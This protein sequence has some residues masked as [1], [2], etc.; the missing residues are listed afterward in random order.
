M[1]RRCAIA[2]AAALWLLAG[3]AQASEIVG[4]YNTGASELEGGVSGTLDVRF[5]ACTDAPGL[6]CGTI[7]AAH[8][9]EDGSGETEMP[10]GQP[11][12]GFTMITG[13]EPRGEGR[14]RDGKINAVDESLDKGK[15]VWYGV[16]VD[17]LESGDLEL[18]GCLGFLCPRKLRWT[19]IGD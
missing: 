19:R 17:R 10:D 3:G 5:H 7:E 9:G 6:T 2:G 14:F 15:M 16:K 18:R 8:E 4:L 1:R 11:I 12:V 13:L